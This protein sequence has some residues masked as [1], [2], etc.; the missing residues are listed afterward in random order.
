MTIIWNPN[1]IDTSLVFAL[2]FVWFAILGVLVIRRIIR[3]VVWDFPRGVKKIRPLPCTGRIL[4][5]P[6]LSLCEIYHLISS[7]CLQKSY[8]THQKQ[9]ISKARGPFPPYATP[10]RIID[11]NF[12]Q[13]YIIGTTTEVYVDS[14]PKTST[15]P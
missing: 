2:Q 3:G 8:Q 7:F 11:R 4:L 12:T 14:D 5:P 1:R 15:K 6:K 9:G 13:L 10:L